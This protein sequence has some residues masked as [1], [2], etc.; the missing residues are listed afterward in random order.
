VFTWGTDVK[1][2]YLMSW[3]KTKRTLFR[4]NVM[5][6]PNAPPSASCSIG[7]DNVLSGSWCLGTIE[8]LKL[9]GKDWWM[10][11]VI[12]TDDEWEY[13]GVVE[14]WLVDSDFSW[15]NERVA[16]SNASDY[17]VSLFPSSIS[18]TDFKVFVYPHKDLELSWKESGSDLNVTPYVRLQLSV[19]PSWELRRRLKWDPEEV[20]FSTTISLTDIFSK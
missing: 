8:F 7:T 9:D 19:V 16:G 12:W 4:W 18:V 6:D 11:H 15:E 14:T 10:D 5:R 13:D 17:Y 3:D 1:E 20:T 2:L